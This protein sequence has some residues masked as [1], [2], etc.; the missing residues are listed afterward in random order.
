MSYFINSQQNKN[1]F[2]ILKKKKKIKIVYVI[3]LR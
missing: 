1:I 3:G 2:S